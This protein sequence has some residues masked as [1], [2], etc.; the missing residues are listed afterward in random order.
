MDDLK[1]NIMSA[2]APTTVDGL[3][4][5][6]DAVESRHLKSDASSLIKVTG[7]RMAISGTAIVIDSGSALRHGTTVIIGTDGKIDW[8]LLKNYASIAVN[9]GLTIQGDL[10][11][12]ITLAVDSTVVRTS[13]AQ[14]IQGNKTFSGSTITISSGQ[15]SLASSSLHMG[16][17][18]ITNVSHITI[19]DPGVNEG[20][21]WLGGSGWKIFESPDDL[22]NAAGNRSEERRVGKDRRSGGR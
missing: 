21:E 16:G 1:L 8:G 6:E 17:G 4:I 2:P 11:Q 15:L 7:G 9:G 3:D 18:S 12:G 14:T 13:G 10:A 20:I 5:R 22:T 19:N